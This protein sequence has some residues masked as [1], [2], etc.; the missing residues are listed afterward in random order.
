MKCTIQQ[1]INV[2]YESLLIYVCKMRVIKYSH[3]RADWINTC[4]VTCDGLAR[5]RQTSQAEG[6]VLHKT[7]HSP[8][9]LATSLWVPRPPALLTNKLNTQGFL[10]SL[11][12]QSFN[13]LTVT[14][15]S[16]KSYTYNYS[17]TIAQIIQIR[18]SKKRCIG[19]SLR[20]SQMCIFW[21]PLS[22]QSQDTS[23]FN[24]CCVTI[25]IVTQGNSYELQCLSFYWSSILWAW[26]IEL[27]AMWLNLISS[28]YSP[29][30]RSA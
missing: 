13:R 5:V 3:H 7:S 21:C 22:L 26:Y 9:K 1:F 2:I 12:A 10:L 27:L 24:H 11:H 23:P 29:P 8:Q 25:H 19:W 16:G 17:V 18:I 4:A 20:R 15:N 14:E 30:W 6:T 28:S